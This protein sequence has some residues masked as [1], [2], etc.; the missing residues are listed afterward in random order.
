MVE[1]DMGLTNEPHNPLATAASTKRRSLPAQAVKIADAPRGGP[2]AN[3]HAELWLR[4]SP[5]RSSA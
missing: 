1:G 3:K 5:S 2:V 4:S